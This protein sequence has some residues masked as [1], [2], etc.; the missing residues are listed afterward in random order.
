MRA[1]AGEMLWIFK[2]Q[3]IA[4][5][6]LAVLRMFCEAARKEAATVDLARRAGEALGRGR[7]GAGG[8]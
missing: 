8:G 6:T 5:E 3:G 1:L 2:A 4:R 7:R